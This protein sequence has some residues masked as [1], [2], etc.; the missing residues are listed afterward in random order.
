MFAPHPGDINIQDQHGDV[1]VDANDRKSYSPYPTFT[2]SFGLHMGWKAFDLSVFLQ[3]VAGLH[4]FV[5]GWGWEPFV[6]G[7]P[8]LAM[9]EKAWSPTNP[10]NTIPAVYIG[11]G[12]YTGGY[13][14]VKAYQSTYELQNASYMRIKSI[15]LAYTISRRMIDR[16]KS[17][18]ISVYI[19]GDNLF[20]FTKY[21]ATDPERAMTGPNGGRAFYYPQVRT[22]NAGLDVKF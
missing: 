18:G 8:P 21:P 22:L 4:S 12:S 20:T 19:S 3:G 15:R 1:V 6:Q 16:I 14:G 2:Y 13:G 17:K 7:D 10:S 5:Y 11:S 9:F